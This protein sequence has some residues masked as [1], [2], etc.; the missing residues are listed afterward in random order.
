MPAAQGVFV[1]GYY[2]VGQRGD[3]GVVIG[4]GRRRGAGVGGG[5]GGGDDDCEEEEE[6]AEEEE[7]EIGGDGYGDGDDDETV[8][9]SGGR[10][11]DG[12][13][14]VVG[15]DGDADAR[16]AGGGI[17][18][19]AA[20][21]GG[22][23]A[24][25]PT[26]GP[27]DTLRALCRRI[28]RSLGKAK[29]RGKTGDGGGAADGNGAFASR[30]GGGDEVRIFR[31]DGRGGDGGNPPTTGR[32][33]RP[34]DIGGPDAPPEP[35]IGPQVT[36]DEN[37]FIVIDQASLLINPES[38]Q[39]TSQIDA[40][41]GGDAVIEE[42]E[43]DGRLG[44]IQARYDAFTTNPRTVPTRWSAKETRAFYDALRQCG[45]DF[46]LVQMFC[47]GR[48]RMQLKRKFKVESRKNPRL[49]DM[50]LDPK[51]KVKLGEFPRTI[52]GGNN[53]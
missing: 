28:P 15:D 3:G 41:L 40:E 46:G 12:T 49:V 47:M 31:T 5:G 24:A 42:G 1:S 17:D 10:R 25:A 53:F 44:A 37:G 19:G 2:V 4:G 22:G 35:P 27:A 9:A 52:V 7:E 34:R 30:G 6:V 26:A 45:T 21:E 39:S 43:N 8:A 33:G 29:K 36:F 23:T 50:A 38:R 48:T 32:D 16:T 11:D 51:C 14:E 18:D 13:E 20:G